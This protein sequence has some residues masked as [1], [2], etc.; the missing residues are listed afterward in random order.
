MFITPLEEHTIFHQN[1]EIILL[2]DITFCF[3]KQYV[4]LKIL[5]ESTGVSMPALRDLKYIQ[6]STVKKTCKK[7][8]C[9]KNCTIKSSEQLKLNQIN[10]FCD[11]PS[12]LK[13]QFS[14]LHYPAVLQACRWFQ[15]YLRTGHNSSAGFG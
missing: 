2:D 8:T 13:L 15:A 1:P 14:Q 9:T 10:I 6:Y 5:S 4:L 11:H 12:P 7:V 3:C